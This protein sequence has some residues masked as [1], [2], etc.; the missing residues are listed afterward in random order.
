MTDTSDATSAV[1][2]AVVELSLAIGQIR[3][4]MRAEVNP[5]E[6]NLSQL[7][8]LVRLEQN[9]WT[10]IADLARGESM[11][12]QS[13]A[14]IL[15]GLEEEGLVT[16]RPHPTDGRQVQFSLTEAGVEARRQRSLAKREWLV[17]A[18]LKLSPAEQRRLIDA[19]PLIRRLGDS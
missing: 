14:T 3:R 12:P 2:R 18:M 15:T 1:E 13:M 7:G 6:F 19:I 4:R 16:R 17:A 11:K 9:G 5:R 8:A 10:T